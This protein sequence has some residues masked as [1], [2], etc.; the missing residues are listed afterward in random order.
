MSSKDSGSCAHID[1]TLSVW[2]LDICSCFLL[3]TCDDKFSEVVSQSFLAALHTYSNNLCRDEC[4]GHA[5]R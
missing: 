5:E 3:K 1:T 4:K 2:Y